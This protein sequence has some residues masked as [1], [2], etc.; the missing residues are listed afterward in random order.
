M[1]HPIALE[2]YDGGKAVDCFGVEA[3]FFWKCPRGEICSS[4]GYDVVNRATR[5]P[6]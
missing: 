3:E 5:L 2:L 1:F 6:L 4:N